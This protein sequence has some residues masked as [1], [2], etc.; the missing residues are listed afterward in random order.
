ML[1]EKVCDEIRERFPYIF[2]APVQKGG[3]T[4]KLVLNRID[5]EPF[6]IGDF[7]ITPLPVYH[8]NLKV[9]GFRT[10]SFAYITDCSRIPDSTLSLLKGVK[11]LVLGALRYRTHETHFS[12]DQA[13]EIIKK[14]S[15]ERA[16]LTHIC[17]EVDHFTLKEELNGLNVEPAY[18]G[19]V[20]SVTL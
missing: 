11:Q 15:P 10:G 12:I 2:T 8:G 5:T 1:W 6:S 9:L 19:Q 17:H 20:I 13:L 16:Y 14:I 7:E 4:P 18:D 3:G